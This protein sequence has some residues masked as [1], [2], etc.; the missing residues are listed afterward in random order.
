MQADT[1]NTYKFDVKVALICTYCILTSLSVCRWPATVAPVRWHAPSR[2][3]RRRALAV[4]KHTLLSLTITHF[5]PVSSYDVSL[6][7]QEV[8]V[9]GTI[10]YDDVLAVI[11]K[12]GKEVSINAVNAPEKPSWYYF[13]QVRS[14]KVVPEKVPENVVPT[15]VVN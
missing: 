6:E 8:F 5:Q 4:S 14:G 10:P 13:F 15:E 11:S 9:T 7:K 2:R 1:E 12:T 3:R